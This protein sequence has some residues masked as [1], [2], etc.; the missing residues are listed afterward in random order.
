MEKILNDTF[1]Q[2]EDIT[3]LFFT[4]LLITIFHIFQINF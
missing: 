3:D 2:I 4:L 1:K